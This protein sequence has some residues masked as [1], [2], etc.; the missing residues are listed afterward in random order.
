MPPQK[1]D[2]PFID[3]RVEHLGVSKLRVM[4]ATDLKGTKT[5][6]IRENDRPLAVLL[7][8]EQYLWM[9]D[10]LQSILKAG[11]M[12]PNPEAPD[13]RSARSRDANARRDTRKSAPEN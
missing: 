9:Q 1:T 8:Y 12:N 11:K 10:K 7:N 4:N 2:L 5:I 3:P 6:V 13:S